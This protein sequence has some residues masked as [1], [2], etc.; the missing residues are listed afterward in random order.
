MHSV[1]AR[2]IVIYWGVTH[3]CGTTARKHRAPKAHNIYSVYMDYID[4]NS[5]NR[6]HCRAMDWNGVGSHAARVY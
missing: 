4:I 1:A 2:H 6:V 5:P 3:M